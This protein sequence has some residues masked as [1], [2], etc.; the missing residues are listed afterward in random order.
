MTSIQ[1]PPPFCFLLSL[2]LISLFFCSVTTSPLSPSLSLS[3]PLR[4][5][6]VFPSPCSCQTH[7]PANLHEFA[8]SVPPCTDVS[9]TAFLP[10]SSSP[11]DLLSPRL[12]QGIIES[13]IDCMGNIDSFPL[14]PFSLAFTHLH[15]SP[16]LFFFFFAS[17]FS[18]YAC[19]S[20]PPSTSSSSLPLASCS[21][22]DRN[23]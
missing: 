20:P 9:S 7:R 22:C 4:F 12:Q 21:F 11:P 3:L 6:P 23:L 17:S 14:L 5:V 8:I 15:P 13:R 18:P 19:H 1:S 2:Y 16:H 10:R